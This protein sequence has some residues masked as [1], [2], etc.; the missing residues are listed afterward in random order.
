MTQ[1]AI[2]FLRANFKGTD[3]VARIP[4]GYYGRSKTGGSLDCQ[5]C[6][7]CA[8]DCPACYNCGCTLR[9]KEFG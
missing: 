9:P 4:I 1:K 8:G 3:V 5:C 7:N 2:A 6:Q